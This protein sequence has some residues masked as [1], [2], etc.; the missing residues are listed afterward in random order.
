LRR[1][2]VTE[3]DEASVRTFVPELNGHLDI[4]CNNGSCFSKGQAVTVGI[5]PENIHL[6]D[7]EQANAF[8][9][10]M[11]RIVEG[12]SLINCFFATKEIDAHKH[13]LEVSLHKSH[14]PQ[15]QEG[16][17]SYIYLP[18]GNITLIKG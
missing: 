16:H 11:E 6:V 17:S 3:V 13:W 8:L 10:N 2:T 12:V 18:P 1:G 9:C 7:R 5:R 15:I 4:Q 14:A